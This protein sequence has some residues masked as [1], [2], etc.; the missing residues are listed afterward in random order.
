MAA[1]LSRKHCSGTPAWLRDFTRHQP[2]THKK[3]QTKQ[4]R[5][6]SEIAFSEMKLEMGWHRHLVQVLR[7]NRAAPAWNYLPGIEKL[8]RTT[9]GLLVPDSTDVS[10]RRDDINLQ[11]FHPDSPFRN[12]WGIKEHVDECW[13]R[14]KKEK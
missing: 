10:S 12:I 5:D 11:H 4:S 13:D 2:L 6:A 14:G 1:H 7:I 9:V 8:T 3:P